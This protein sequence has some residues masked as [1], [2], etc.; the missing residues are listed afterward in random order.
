M[1]KQEIKFETITPL[2]TGSVDAREMKIIQPAS[3]MGSLRFWFDVICHFSG[4]FKDNRFSKKEFN[5][6]KYEKFVRSNPK[7]TDEEIC[8]ELQLSPTARYFG[9]TG[10]KSRIGIEKITKFEN[11]KEVE[12]KGNDFKD[13][14]DIGGQ[15]WINIDRNG[16]PRDSCW[17]IPYTYYNGE[18]M[19]T[20][21]TENKQIAEN[22]L[23]P[24]LNF[25]QEYGFLGGKNNIGFGRVKIVIP[26]I[27]SK[28]EIKIG[29]EFTTPMDLVY[30]VDQK[31][32]LLNFNS[33][34]VFFRDKNE[35]DFL[36]KIES[37]LNIKSRLRLTEGFTLKRHFIFGSTSDKNG[38]YLRIDRESEK[39]DVDVPNATKIIPLIS[40]DKIGFLGIPGI[41]TMPEVTR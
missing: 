15:L 5:H 25:I 14:L 11:N 38:F 13:S 24:L 18:F 33:I 3:I 19:I 31:S 35:R 7:A 20:F 12:F 27:S 32:E 41:I 6:K 22:I 30:K 1:V 40:E 10:W 28:R 2:Y 17:F 29:N 23:Y 9:C 8:D 39:Y 4:K 36:K 37:L 21:T 26:D 16:K 34:N